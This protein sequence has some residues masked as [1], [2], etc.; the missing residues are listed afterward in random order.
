MRLKQSKGILKSNIKKIN[1]FKLKK[2][3]LIVDALFGIGLKRN[4]KGILKKI[5]DL[6]NRNNNPCCFG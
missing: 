2:E 6:I 3:A 5:F 4:I 1:F